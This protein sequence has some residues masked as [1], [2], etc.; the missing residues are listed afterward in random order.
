MPAGPGSRGL[1]VLP[2]DLT[3]CRYRRV[4]TR[5]AGTGRVSAEDPVD[6]LVGRTA[7]RGRALLRRAAVVDT[8]PT[9]PRFGE[10]TVPSRVDIDP[11]SATAEEETLEAIAAGTRIITGARLAD[12]ALACEVDLLVRTDMVNVPTPTM[13]YM[14]V[15]VTSHTVSAAARKRSP[16]VRVVDVAALSLATPQPAQVKHRSTPADSQRV[17]V[18][19]VLLQ[20]AEVASG[21]VGFIGTDIRSCLVIPAERVT[22]GLMRSL[23]SPVPRA[24]VRVKEC[25]HCEFHNHCRA[26]LLRRGDLS[27]MLP[28]DKATHWREQGIDTLA[29]LAAAEEG[30]VSALASAWMAGVGYLRRPLQRWVTHGDLWCGHRFRMPSRRDGAVLPMAEELADAEE[31]DVDMEAHP[32]RGTFLW[33]TFDGSVY[34]SFTDFGRQDDGGRHVAVFWSWLMSRRRAALDDGRVFRAYC[35][36]QQGENHWLRHYARTYGGTSY[37][38]ETDGSATVTMPSL[39]EVE[40][41]L[42]SD[43][44]VDVFALVK[45]AIAANSSLG[46]KAVAPLAGFTFSQDDV[47]GRVAVDLF[48]VAVGTSRQDAQIAQRTLERYNADDCYATAAVRRWLRLGAPGIPALSQPLEKT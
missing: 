31:I 4:L 1:P 25:G 7:S 42:R 18:A 24:P 41:F 26:R 21:D 36:A 17:A 10:R 6:V 46:L 2:A 19:H 29:E 44:W 37:L 3:G 23:E 13:T 45:A 9:E 48:E 39:E 11:D 20:L 8:L 38:L 32:S 27:L 14:P 28:G 35:Y 22:P 12:G 47:D 30:E 34:R 43:E 40:A 15:V 5:A 33:G 16:G